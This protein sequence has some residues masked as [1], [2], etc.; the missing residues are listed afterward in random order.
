[1]GSSTNTWPPLRTA[2]FLASLAFVLCL[3]SVASG[4][5]QKKGYESGTLRA[6]G[7]V[8]VATRDEL[9]GT[10]YYKDLVAHGVEEA[11]IVD[12]ILVVGRMFCCRD[13]LKASAPVYLF[14]PRAIMVAPG[15]IIEFQ[16]GEVGKEVQGTAAEFNIVTRV[17]QQADQAD[18]KCWWEPKDDRMWMRFIVCEWMPEQGWIKQSSFLYR[19]W[20]KPADVAKVK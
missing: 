19:G 13:N 10:S 2:T 9:V 7:V 20:Y 1:M 11:A 8:H 12:G 14:N 3:V 17:L 18:G 5:D 15:D 4:T 16:I 6:A